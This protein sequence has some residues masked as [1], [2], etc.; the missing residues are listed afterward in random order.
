MASKTANK[1]SGIRGVPR[2]RFLRGTDTPV[3][4]IRANRRFAWA[5]K[6]EDGGYRRVEVS[7]TELR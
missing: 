1:N 2:A 6:E 4:R 5:V 3:I 7:E